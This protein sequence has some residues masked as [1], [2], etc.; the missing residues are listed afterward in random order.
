MEPT[1]VNGHSRTS[2]MQN[3]GKPATTDIGERAL[4]LPLQDNCTVLLQRLPELVRKQL[5]ETDA[6]IRFIVHE[7]TGRKHLCELGVLSS[8]DSSCL[9]A[10]RDGIF[11]YNAQTVRSHDDFT[12]VFIV[13]TGIGAE[14]GGD[15]GDATPALRLIASICDRVVTHPNVVNASD[16][17]EIPDNCLYV[18]GSVLTKFMMGTVGLQRVRS[19]RIGVLIGDH[20]IARYKDIAVNAV[21]AARAT[22]GADCPDVVMLPSEVQMR[23]ET[24]P[25]GRAVGRIKGFEYILEA[26]A[27]YGQRWDA[28]A[29]ASMVDV[30]YDTFVRYWDGKIINPWGGVEAILTHAISLLTNKESAH[31][32]MMESRQHETHNLGV[33]DPRKAAEAISLA[34]M[35]CIMKGLWRSPRIVPCD[36]SGR[37]PAALTVGDVDC[38]IIPDGVVGLPTLSAMARHIPIIAVR[39]NENLM[40]NHLERY[41]DS[42]TR[43]YYASSYLEAAGIV[44]AL[45]GGVAIDAIKRPMPVTTITELQQH[46]SA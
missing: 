15:A 36:T 22:L 20:K 21:S 6:P 34:F 30:D 13:P 4:E 32:P 27:Q 46:A 26:I 1:V 16:I 8:S 44:A 40:K 41:V 33:T 17:N 9:P 3:G 19:N 43:L 2:T 35:H 12:A 42:G 45:R 10:D 37:A 7:T 14:V 24:S 11:Q 31:C 39:G 25:S 28:I 29:I 18:E 38:L 23:A 5:D